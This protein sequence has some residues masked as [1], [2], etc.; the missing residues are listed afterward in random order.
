M[1]G[2]LQ[3]SRS[4]CVRPGRGLA[5]ASRERSPRPGRVKRKSRPSAFIEISA[6]SYEIGKEIFI[7]RVSAESA[8]ADGSSHANIAAPGA[9]YYM[10]G[11]TH[12]VWEQ[13]MAPIALD[14]YSPLYNSSVAASAAS[15]R[16]GGNGQF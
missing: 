1:G 8:S 3:W 10:P 6:T 15:S 5:G 12:S 9:T 11:S 16:A 2:N 7:D 13:Y 4:A 14:G